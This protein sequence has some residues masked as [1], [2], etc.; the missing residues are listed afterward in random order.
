MFIAIISDIHD[1]LANLHKCLTWCQKNRIEKI[2]FCGDATTK[3]TISYLASNFPNEIFIVH[4]NA[5]IYTI[6]ELK[7]YQNINYCQEIGKKNLDHT[8]I[9]FCHKPKEINNL[10]KISKN[11]LNFIFYGHTHK[12]D[13]KQNKSTIIANPGNLAGTLYPATFAVLNTKNEVLQLKILANL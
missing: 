5:E 13:F 8:E 6:T 4:G 3:E 11:N 9:A 1:N 2:I 12:P 7:K 10:L